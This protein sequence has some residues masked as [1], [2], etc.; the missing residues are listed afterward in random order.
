VRTELSESSKA[1]K[2]FDEKGINER[3][4]EDEQISW[5]KR[6]RR[7]EKNSDEAE[8][9]PEP[10]LSEALGKPPCLQTVE[11]IETIEWPGS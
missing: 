11:T 10:P 5:K 4:K 1:A 8:T 7:C 2:K 3:E 9:E 6:M